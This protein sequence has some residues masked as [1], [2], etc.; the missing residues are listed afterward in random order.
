MNMSAELWLLGRHLFMSSH[1][2]VG[3]TGST[4]KSL[5]QL[6]LKARKIK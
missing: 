1:G 4:A 3:Q 5:L 6:H 2:K